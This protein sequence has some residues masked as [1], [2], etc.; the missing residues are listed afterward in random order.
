MSYKLKLGIKPVMSDDIT[1]LVR[2]E[3]YLISIPLTMGSLF[4]NHQYKLLP[5]L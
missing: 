3:N 2:L 5:Q 1:I 4:G